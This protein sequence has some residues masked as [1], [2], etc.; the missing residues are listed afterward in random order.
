LPGV[1]AKAIPGAEEEEPQSPPDLRL[2]L[3]RYRTW[4]ACPGPWHRAGGLETADALRFLPALSF[5]PA[6][7]AV[8]SFEMTGAYG[9]LVIG[10]PAGESDRTLSGASAALGI[11][12]ASGILA[13]S[14]ISTLLLLAL[15]P[16]LLALFPPL[17][18]RLPVLLALLLALLA[19]F[20]A[21]LTI[22]G[23]VL[24]L[25]TTATLAIALASGSVTAFAVPAS[26]WLVASVSPAH[27]FLLVVSI[28]QNYSVSCTRSGTGVTPAGISVSGAGR[29]A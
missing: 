16:A 11:S 25:L 26:A 8:R 6:L 3:P 27:E 7:T 13:T 4:R 5:G 9:P 10:A 17:L 2:A 1:G 22:R 20:L 23:P 21:L 24:V 19:L 14:G 28:A 18:P 12:T 15:L 29:R